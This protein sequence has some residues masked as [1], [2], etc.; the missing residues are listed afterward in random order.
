MLRIKN[1]AGEELLTLKD[2]GTEEFNSQQLKE[3]FKQAEEKV[4]NKGE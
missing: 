2:D 4:D 1:L 3:E